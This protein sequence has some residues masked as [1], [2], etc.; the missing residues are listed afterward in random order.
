MLPGTDG[1]IPMQEMSSNAPA[2]YQPASI[3]SRFV[4]VLIDAVVAFAIAIPLF[5]VAGIMGAINDALGAL[6]F[7][8][9]YLA[10]LAFSA[11]VYMWGLG[12]TGQT[13]GKRSQGV[14]VLS[15]ETGQPIGGIMGVARYFLGAIINVFCYADFLSAIF[16]G[17]NQRISD[18]ILK[19]QAYQ[20][21]SGSITPI[22]PGGKPF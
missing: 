8:L 13:P 10:L 3:G 14:I 21:Q 11:Y 19:A 18:G 1:R 20:V 2:G 5:V 15:T 16:K 4:A 9:A 12:E 22:F 17:D 6:V 7:I